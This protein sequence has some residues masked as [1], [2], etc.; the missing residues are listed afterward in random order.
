M[1]ALAEA[2]IAGVEQGAT[3]T[4]DQDLSEAEHVLREV[5]SLQPRFE[6]LVRRLLARVDRLRRPPFRNG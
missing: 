1:V 2:L 5:L 4:E 3:D 6:P